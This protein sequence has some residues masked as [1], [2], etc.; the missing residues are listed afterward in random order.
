MYAGSNHR[1]LEVIFG[2]EVFHDDGS[3]FAE[4][5][6]EDGASCSVSWDDSYIQLIVPAAATYDDATNIVTRIAN[7]GCVLWSKEPVGCAGNVT[8]QATVHYDDEYGREGIEIGVT[9]NAA[10]S[11]AAN[12]AYENS[13]AVLQRA[14]WM[15]SD[16]GN[17]WVH[18]R[19]ERHRNHNGKWI[20]NSTWEHTTPM[21]LSTGDVVR[22]EVTAQGVMCIAVNDIPQAEWD[23]TICDEPL[24]CDMP[25][26]ALV[27]LRHPCKGASVHLCD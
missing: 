22:C 20:T 18:G 8:F 25:L 10:N 3:S 19:S 23:L 1:N 7:R 2:G 21:Q 16:A 24:P 11:A 5:G 13:Y 9:T 6:L 12:S 14:S 26:Y 27:G 4:Q 15:S 17:L